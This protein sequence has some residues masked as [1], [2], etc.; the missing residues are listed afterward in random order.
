MA[1]ILKAMVEAEKPGLVIMGKQAIDDDCN[2]TGQMLAALL[3]LG[4]GHL[5]LQAR[6]RGRRASA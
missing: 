3:G 6:D 5:R 1:K 4:A 2:Q